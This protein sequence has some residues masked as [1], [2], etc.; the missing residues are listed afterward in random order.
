MAR[1][2]QPAS[3][4]PTTEQP[5]GEMVHIEIIET[6]G[7]KDEMNLVEYPFASLWKNE[8]TEREL[9]FE[10]EKK[11]PIT[12]QML[13]AS[14]RVTGDPKLGLPTPSDE[15]LY[16]VLME[17]TCEVGMN[18]QM[19]S[20][21]RY[22]VLKRMGWPDDTRSYRM[23][24]EAFARLMGVTIT[25]KNAFWNPVQ[26]GFSTDAFHILDNYKLVSETRGRKPKDAKDA[27]R[28]SSFFKWNDVLFQSF[29]G[30]NIR[31]IDVA[32]AL[33]LKRPLSLRLFRYLDKKVFDG[34][35]RFEI[36][37]RDLCEIHLGMAV[38]G[39][40]DADLRA[41][42]KP[43]HAELVER[44]FLLNATFE[45]L[46][47]RKGQKVCYEFPPPS[48]RACLLEAKALP[49]PQ[50]AL[51]LPQEGAN[52]GVSPSAPESA[53]SA[54]SGA[55]EAASGAVEAKG[56]DVNP[57]ADPDSELLQRMLAI[58]VSRSVAQELESSVD[59]GH[60]AMQLDCLA[61]RDAK[62]PAALFVK[63]VREVWALPEAYMAR[64]RAVDDAERAKSTVEA[65]E[66]NKARQRAL[67]CQQRASQQAE[68]VKLD[69]M[70]EKLDAKTRER[71][72]E[73]VKERLGPLATIGLMRGGDAPSGA[74]CAM[75][76]NLMREMLGLNL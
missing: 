32:F 52:P 21:T 19:V 60:L 28:P 10:W 67:E 46:K 57:D 5:T 68:A 45:I 61:D 31:T 33:S 14:W 75:R 70:W 39:R 42:L 62:S 22:D 47:T 66:T 7:G 72:D 24:E 59:A 16:L 43:A 38:D 64:R 51:P 23:L 56:S 37:L 55:A 1:K 44:G 65:Q 63:A 41:G 25:A 48:K 74:L 9:S 49:A 20:F 13:P 12:G 8:D 3:E 18:Q 15:K 50:K 35:R 58:G 4:Q 69:A 17:L 40:Y 11:H 54:P 6:R 26:K 27:P 73:E 30:G 2:K 53:P 34:R 76:R 29:V 36:G 71:L